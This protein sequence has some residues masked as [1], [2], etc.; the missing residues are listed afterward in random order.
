M[1]CALCQKDAVLRNSHILPEF[2]YRPVYVRPHRAIVISTDSNLKERQAQKGVREYLLC[3]ECEQK[4]SRWE[5][6]AKENFADGPPNHTQISSNVIL[7]SGLD[8]KTFRLFELSLL[9]RMG[10]SKSH[11]FADV[12]LG[13]HTEILRI[14]LQNENPLN[15]DQYPCLHFAVKINGKFH[16]D[17]VVF[18]SLHKLNGV[19][20]YPVFLNG[21]VYCFM[22]GSHQA[23]A[24]LM[25]HYLNQNGQMKVSIYEARDLPFLRNIF[26]D[27]ARAMARRK[28][29][30]TRKPN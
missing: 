12:E 11:Y 16:T 27:F 6:Y 15:F 9:W 3:D 23:S 13:S 10:V 7:V 1:A 5:R 14:A 24:H 8:F 18:P 4:F 2:F 29:T 25:D 30:N 17:G 19:R 26:A 22:V 21:L 28:A 20:C